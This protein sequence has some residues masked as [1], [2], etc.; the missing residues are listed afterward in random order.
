MKKRLQEF[1]ENMVK[2]GAI[3]LVL[4]LVPVLRVWLLLDRGMKPERREEAASVL[5]ESRAKL[6]RIKLTP[7]LAVGLVKMAAVLFFGWCTM[8]A[9]F[10]GTLR[11]N[12]IF[13][14]LAVLVAVAPVPQRWQP[15][16]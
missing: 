15:K 10:Y 13:L 7:P 16:T 4:A 8:N 2:L 12:I 1:K 6:G 11:D 3:L 5:A 14:L 9:F